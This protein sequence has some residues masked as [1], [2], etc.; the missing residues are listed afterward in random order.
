MKE[1][2]SVTRDSD[3]VSKIRKISEKERTPQSKITG[4]V[5]DL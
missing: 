3:L 2:V 4:E 5:G 1:R